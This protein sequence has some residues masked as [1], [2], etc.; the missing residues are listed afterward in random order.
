MVEW[1]LKRTYP[2]LL[3]CLAAAVIL[4]AVPVGCGKKGPPRLPN[5]K[6]PTGVTDLT[7]AAEGAELV[8]SWTAPK[9]SEDEEA[10][11]PAGYLV[12]RS[13]EPVG[14]ETCEGCPVLF[15][16]VEKIP[17]AE[18]DETGQTQVY[19]EALLSGTR[20]R[21]KVVSYDVRGQLGPDSNIVKIVTD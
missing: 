5:I 3:L 2:V 11:R 16:R 6:T 7:L 1:C 8:L 14:E 12:Y 19:R 21:F 17:L 10:S 9:V 4:A 13:T 15:Q 18:D 20:Y